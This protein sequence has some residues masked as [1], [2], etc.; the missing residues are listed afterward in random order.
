MVSGNIVQATCENRCLKVVKATFMAVAKIIFAT[1]GNRSLKYFWGSFM[2]V[3]L[4]FF[5]QR[6]LIFPLNT[7][8]TFVMHHTIISLEIFDNCPFKY[9]RGQLQ[10]VAL[11]LQKA[12][13]NFNT[14]YFSG[15]LPSKLF[16]L[17]N[18]TSLKK[19]LRSIIT[20]FFI[21]E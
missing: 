20:I 5:Q 9:F 14:S 3:T 12:N 7:Y 2:S 15:N 6:S 10:V 11:V 16:S 21:D 1:L 18:K 17:K 13:K 4:L 19:L 8:G